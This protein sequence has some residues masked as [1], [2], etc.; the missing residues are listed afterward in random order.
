LSKTV[1]SFER[2]DSLFIER[3]LKDYKKLLH[4]IDGNRMISEKIEAILEI[5]R[6]ADES[7]IEELP[8]EDVRI[9]EC[10]ECE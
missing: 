10:N 1:A 5:I 9:G 3:C 8:S 6:K 7:N 4:I 2:D